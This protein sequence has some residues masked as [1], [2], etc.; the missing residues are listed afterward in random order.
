MVV[1][2]LFFSGSVVPSVCSLA[3]CKE[4]ICSLLFQNHF[5]PVDSFIIQLLSITTLILLGAQILPNLPNGNT[6]KQLLCP[7][8]LF[9]SFFQYVLAFCH[10]KIFQP[11]CPSSDSFYCG[12]VFKNKDLE[13]SLV[14]QW[15]RLRLPV[16]GSGLNPWFGELGSHMPCG[17]KTKT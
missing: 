17:Q 16:R 3:F 11:L 2:K 10:S 9:P 4:E 13:T 8:H 5:G 12:T 6:S 15:L 7:F 1:I 14:V